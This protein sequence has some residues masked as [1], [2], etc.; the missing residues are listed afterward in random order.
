[1]S[2]SVKHTGYFKTF[3]ATD[4]TLVFLFLQTQVLPPA[5][6]ELMFTLQLLDWIYF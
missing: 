1:M 6:S 5:V 3:T 2:V 4:A